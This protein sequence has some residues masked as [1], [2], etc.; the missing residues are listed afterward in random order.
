MN[1]SCKAAFRIFVSSTLAEI[2]SLHA[3]TGCAYRD[4]LYP[5]HRHCLSLLPWGLSTRNIGFLGIHPRFCHAKDGDTIVISLA[6]SAN[7]TKLCRTLTFITSSQ[8]QTANESVLQVLF[9]FVIVSLTT[10]I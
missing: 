1:I 2:E 4:W 3:I 6:S 10:I 5:A 8:L 7:F 9:L